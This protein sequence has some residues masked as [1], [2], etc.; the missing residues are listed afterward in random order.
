MTLLPKD[1][2]MHTLYLL[3]PRFQSLLRPL[4]RWL[5]V[6]GATANQITVLACCLSAG[7]GLLA[8]SS[9][10]MLL[11]L[12]AFFVVRM[13]LNALDGVLARDFG[14]KSNLGACLNEVGD[15]VSDSF[16]YLPFA[17]LPEFDPLWMGAVIVLVVIAELA[18]ITVLMIGAERRYDGPMGKSDRALVFGLMALWLGTG[19]RLALWECQLFPIAI[20]VLL[21]ITIVNRVRGG[22]ADAAQLRSQ[23]KAFR[24]GEG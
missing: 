2:G 17:R 9:R 21:A 18:G 22:L 6:A 7:V 20:A 5:V 13:A 16:L 24:R 19:G 11:L 4:A 3:K 15:V 10:P 23:N 14:Q 8:L 12:P 1:G